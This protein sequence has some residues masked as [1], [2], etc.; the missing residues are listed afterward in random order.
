MRQ[1]LYPHADNG[2]AVRLPVPRSMTELMGL[3]AAA[4]VSR[5]WSELLQRSRLQG[6]FSTGFTSFG[7]LNKRL[8]AGGVSMLS[9]S[10]STLSLIL[11]SS[12]AALLPS[13]LVNRR[14]AAYGCR[15]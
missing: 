2:F 6:S 11:P 4:F 10:I 13:L 9:E 1:A 14:V 15:R 8:V 5:L 7:G 3:G 12:A